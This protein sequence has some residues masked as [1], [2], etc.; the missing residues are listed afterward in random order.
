MFRWPAS[1]ADLRHQCTSLTN[2]RVKFHPGLAYTRRCGHTH[3]VQTA[4][5]EPPQSV[6]TRITSAWR[7]SKGA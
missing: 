6:R 7:S 3:L 5:V 1:G 2:L 4:L